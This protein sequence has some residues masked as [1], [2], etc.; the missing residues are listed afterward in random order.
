MCIMQLGCNLVWLLLHTHP[1]DGWRSGG[2]DPSPDP[3]P[4]AGANPL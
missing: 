2:A 1:T 4:N 3:S